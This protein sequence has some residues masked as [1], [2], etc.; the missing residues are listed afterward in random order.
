M[1]ARLY[2]AVD[3]C[4]PVGGPEAGTPADLRLA[5]APLVG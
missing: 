4:D 5:S 2:K 1:S 3:D